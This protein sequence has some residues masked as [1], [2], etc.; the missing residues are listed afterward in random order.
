MLCQIDK[1]ISS[2]T[3]WYS[4]VSF[5]KKMND[6]VF[7]HSSHIYPE[8]Q[9][10]AGTFRFLKSCCT[11]CCGLCFIRAFP[12]W[13]R[14]SMAVDQPDCVITWRQHQC[15]LSCSSALLDT[16]ANVSFRNGKSALFEASHTTLRKQMQSSI[17]PIQCQC[18]PFLPPTTEVWLSGH[19]LV[20]QFWVQTAGS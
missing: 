15:I 7:L 18:F 10:R 11:R 4:R 16:D 13:R 3:R 19:S 8:Y 12:W 6:P 2:K 1:N 20:P 17:G 5:P 14:A 9:P